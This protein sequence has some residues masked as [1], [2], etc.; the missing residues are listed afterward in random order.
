MD[1]DKPKKVGVNS[2]GFRLFF[3]HLHG[4]KYKTDQHNQL[5]HLRS[6]TCLRT[7]VCYGRMPKSGGIHLLGKEV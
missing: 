6:I 4:K 1:K 5:Q 3:T 7:G 2:F